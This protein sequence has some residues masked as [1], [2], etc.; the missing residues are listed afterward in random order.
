MNRKRFLRFWTA[1]VGAMDAVT[2]LLLMF[3]PFLVFRGLGITPPSVGLVFVGW[4]GAFVAA[5]GLGY[6][7]VWIRAGFGEPVWMFTALVRSVVAVFVAVRVLDGSLEAR[8]MVVG[9]TDAAV[10]IVQVMILRA[11]WWREV[12]P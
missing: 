6:G 5:V 7:L 4:I 10:A 1:G 8:W 2:G 9:V 3:A 11:G 12:P